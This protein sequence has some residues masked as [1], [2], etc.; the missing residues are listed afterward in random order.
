MSAGGEWTKYGTFSGALQ[1][2]YEGS[3]ENIQRLDGVTKKLIIYLYPH[4][5]VIKRLS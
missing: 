3:F 2:T 1:L 4:W 5:Q